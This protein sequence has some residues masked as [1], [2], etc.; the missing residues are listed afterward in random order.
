MYR[1][2]RMIPCRDFLQTSAGIVLLPYLSRR[3]RLP[4]ARPRSRVA[5]VRTSDRCA[6]VTEGL[7]L[8]DPAEI[9]G[10]RVVVKPNFNR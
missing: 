8:F 10:K 4:S 1:K 3:I 7:R 5:L 6:G 9:V 2:P